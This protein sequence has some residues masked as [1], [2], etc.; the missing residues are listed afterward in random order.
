MV[1]YPIHA[2]ERD[3]FGLLKAGDLSTAEGGMLVTMAQDGYDLKV[4]KVGASVSATTKMFGL[5]DEQIL[6]TKETMLGKFIPANQMPIVMGPATHLSSGKASVWF[7]SGMFLTDKYTNVTDATPLGVAL[8]HNSGILDGVSG[9]N[10]RVILMK[11]IND[12]SDLLA[13]RVTPVPT[14]GMFAEQAPILI[15]QI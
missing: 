9:G 11:V 3:A 14:T 12:L 5:L 8:Y 13:T 15:Y 10:T 1:L 2:R 4:V 7:E 6:T